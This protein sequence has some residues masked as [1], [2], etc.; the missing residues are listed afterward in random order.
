M[1]ERFEV[2]VQKV[3]LVFEKLLEC[4]IFIFYGKVW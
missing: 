2:F 1:L 4:K 3:K